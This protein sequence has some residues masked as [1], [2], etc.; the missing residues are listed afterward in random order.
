MYSAYNSKELK[1]PN[2]LFLI[3]DEQRYPP[4]Y[5]SEALKE[6]RKENLIT[7]EILRE[8]GLSFLNHYIGSTACSPSRTTLFTGQ[9]PSLHGVAQTTG[10]TNP[11]WLD[12]NTVPT[13]GAYFRTAGYQTFWRGKWQLS[14]ENILIPGTHKA[15]PSYDITTG[16]P[17]PTKQ[18]LYT[19]ANRLNAYGFN[20]WIGPEPLGADPRN[21]GSSANIGISGRDKIY[22]AEVVELIQSLEQ[23]QNSNQPW[24]IV[25]SL[26][27]PHDITL[28]GS[29]SRLSSQFNFEIDPSVPEVPPSPT[30]KEDLGTKPKAHRNYREVFQKAFQPTI[31]TVFYR[32]LY[33]SLHK[34]VDEELFS[35]YSALANSIFYEDTIIIF[36]SDHGSLLGAHGGLF[37][38]WHN[39]YEEVLHVP[40]I[41]HSPKLF[42]EPRETDLL[43]SHVDILPTLLG[44]AGINIEDIQEALRKTHSEVHPFVGRNLASFI[45]GEQTI[46]KA[47]EPLYFMTDDAVPK[48]INQ[49]SLQGEPYSSVS[50]PNHLETI[51]LKLPTGKEDTEEI[52]KYTRYFDNP[53]FWSTP[54]SEDI[55]I[56]QLITTKLSDTKEAAMLIKTTKTQPVEAEFELYNLTRDPLEQ[57]NLVHPLHQTAETKLV[58]LL[59]S[60]VLKQQRKQKRIY[61]SN[62]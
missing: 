13:L 37:Q 36:T 17:D 25:A 53:Q 8:N 33:Y 32:K 51:I 27:N 3:V 49:T 12:A 41:I 60:Q 23:D 22:A 55:E 28:Y 61:P 54:N 48:G 46:M 47:N 40:F 45:I 29:L 24:L 43:T 57:D 4:C 7:Q 59:L 50:Q 58:Q 21:S 20:G 62:K 38:K 56:Q 15:L 1:R 16:I 5:E 6:W 18:K 2:I 19:E 26:V 11:Y 35:I 44:L 9:Y 10:T 34:R 39:A 52:W 31:D 14:D 42:A 30:S